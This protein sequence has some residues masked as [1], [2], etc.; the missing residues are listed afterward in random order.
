[1]LDM[2][3]LEA[4]RLKGEASKKYLPGQILWSRHQ[5][6]VLDCGVPRQNLPPAKLKRKIGQ[7]VVPRIEPFASGDRSGMNDTESG[8]ASR[9]HENALET[10]RHVS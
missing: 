7:L 8:N 9:S 1:M 4:A 3:S 10:P 5:S 6:W 2:C